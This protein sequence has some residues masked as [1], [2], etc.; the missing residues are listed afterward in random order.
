[1]TAPRPHVARSTFD[2]LAPLP[3]GT[4]VLEASAGTGKTHA[5]V[6]LAARYIAEGVD[7]GA[8]LLVTF[9]RMATAELRERTRER[10][11][12]LAAGLAD[13]ASARSDS[14]VTALA[15]AP[16]DEVASRRARISAALSDFDAATVST[17]H[18]FC[19]R[20][21]DALG[22]AGE[23]EHGLTLVEEVD[24][25][26]AEVAG[27]VF[28]K[29]YSGLDE[30]PF[31]FRDA[32]AIA[33]DG[34][35]QS[36]ATLVP[37]DAPEGTPARA[38]TDFVTAVRREVLRRKRMMR[39]RDYDELQSLLRDVITDPVHGEAACARIR[40][41]FSVVLVDE[42]QDTDPIQWEILRRCFHG[43]S[44]LI[45]VGDPKQSIYAFR[46]AE[47]LSYLDAANSADNHQA[48]GTNWRSD[49]GLVQALHHLYGGAALGHPDIVVRPVDA[50][51]TSSRLSGRP[52]LRLRHL[53]RAGLGPL[54]DN[55]FP[56][57]SAVR[58]AVVDDVARDVATL[59]AD[60]PELT[61]PDGTTRPVRPSDVVIL[62]RTRSTIAP[63]QRALRDAGVASVVG[64]G[65]SVFAT[66]SARDWFHVLR[67]LEQPNR[68]D[69]VT[70][71]AL[72][73]LIGR[74][75]GE[76]DAAGGDALAD[77][78]DLLID[79]AQTMAQAGFAAMYERLSIRTGLESRI[80]SGVDGER[81]MTDIAHLAS[82]CNRYVVTE[83]RGIAG[84]LRWFVDRLDDPRVGDQTEQSRRLDRDAQAVSIM[85]VHGSKGLEFPIVYVP[86]G[87]DAARNPYP[88]TLVL[89][90]SGDRILDVGGSRSAEFARN[91]R[92][93]E[94]EDVGE[95]LR[96]FYVAVTRARCQ[97]VLWWAAGSSARSAPLHRLLFARTP[98]GAD[99]A[100]PDPGP[101]ARV[102]ADASIASDLSAWAGPA[103]AL[104][105][106]EHAGG[107]S[108][109]SPPTPSSYGEQI[110][111]RAADFDRVIDHGWRR[112]SYSALVADQH[113]AVGTAIEAD[114]AAV[115]TDE[116]EDAVVTDTTADGG[117]SS[118]MNGLPAGATFGLLV[119]SVL[120]NVDTDAADLSAEVRDRCARAAL[121]SGLQVDVDVLAHAMDSVLRTPL[122]LASGVSDLAGVAMS[123]RLAEMDFEFPLASAT[124]GSTLAAIADLMDDH[125][126]ADDP[127]REYPE[128]LRLIPGAAL[129]GFLTGS[130]DGVLRT[131]DE[132]FVIVDY[133]TNRLG[134]GDLTVEDYDEGAM[135][136]EM[137]RSHYPLQAMLY[138]VA[139]HRYLRWRLPGYRPDRHL[140]RVLYLFVRAMVG[141][142]TPPDRGVFGWDVPP[143]LVE[144]L[145]ELLGGQ[146]TGNRS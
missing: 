125:L 116:P 142:D 95:E 102:P 56:P 24:D 88:P 133:K 55:G 70:L 140:G 50:T 43:H 39:I 136:A 65:S 118:L 25:L 42:F 128:R 92:T 135:A 85:T 131:A 139:L 117:A 87:W 67:A 143:A 103:S 111:L 120:E 93:A 57:L 80:L 124:R 90:E 109:S 18:T 13:P 72:T 89:H 10:L 40:D 35:R 122:G 76:I 16:A 9:S 83:S 8:L 73:P 115:L 47:V 137:M 29:W 86:F 32:V 141:P 77:A 138:S 91:R 45:L 22:I 37:R 71:A 64:A 46:G 100:A 59:L 38:R 19:S 58:S 132:R 34:V 21:L 81:V 52:P 75:A 11:T 146:T 106:V 78:G 101:S 30:P 113:V 121:A 130:I 44:D 2:L 54:G 127:L 27:D 79:L 108:T 49:A 145:S 105:S 68:S 126:P 53:G 94:A 123:D 60:A 12:T 107:G 74:S 31:D 129:D 26:V 33:R 112:T 41:F 61:D 104:V 82:L 99:T 134:F 28:L 15:D 84:L 3:T 114:V 23:S 48:L 98:T 62:L 110:T 1:M 144:A 63:V 51:H 5:I 36:H 66:A 14:L 69:R 6:G 4:T 7:V 20:M 97:V 119:H 96:L 17:T